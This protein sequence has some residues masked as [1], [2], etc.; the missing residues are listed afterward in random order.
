[1]QQNLLRLIW[2]LHYY[3]KSLELHT[4]QTQPRTFRTIGRLIQCKLSLPQS[5]SVLKLP[6]YGNLCLP[7]HR[8]YKIFDFHRK[9]VVKMITGGVDSVLVSNEIEAVRLASQLDFAPGIL[10]S[11]VQ[12]RYYEEEFIHGR[13]FY[14]DP[15]AKTNVSI[16]IYHRDITP[17]LVEMILLQS[18][19]SVKIPE[20]IDRLMQVTADRK[21]MISKENNHQTNPIFDF[22]ESMAGQ[23]VGLTDGR[24]PLVFSHGD[25]SLVNILKTGNGLKVIDWEGSAKRNPL[26]DLYNY[27]LTESYYGRTSK[28]LVTEIN[29]AIRALQSAIAT[30]APEIASTLE[31]LSNIYRWLYYIERI[32]MLLERNFSK[33]L[34]EVVSR[35][36]SVFKN[37]EE[38]FAKI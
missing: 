25:F 36:I 18:I 20:Y 11:N 21:N 31:S 29:Q 34:L 7:V 8:G 13:P 33:K 12:E 24:I 15:L 27:F 19:Q 28:C 9:K 4:G 30:K 22:I 17:C 1:M 38:N 16:E 23:V 2:Y 32:C 10:L 14:S 37:Y 3:C 6:F 26:Y 5:V 35:S